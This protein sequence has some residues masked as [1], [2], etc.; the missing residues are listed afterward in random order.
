MSQTLTNE[1]GKDSF[2]IHLIREVEVEKPKVIL[3]EEYQVK[4]KG[5][6]KKNNRTNSII[7]LLLKLKRIKLV[8]V[9]ISIDKKERKEVVK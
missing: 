6:G 7:T 4:G 8:V 9:S 2:V 5:K 3:Y 1:K